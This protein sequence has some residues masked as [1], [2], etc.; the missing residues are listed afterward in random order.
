MIDQR[1]VALFGYG[2]SKAYFPAVW[3]AECDD[4]HLLDFERGNNGSGASATAGRAGHTDE[5]AE[6]DDEQHFAKQAEYGARVYAPTDAS[7]EAPAPVPAI[8]ELIPEDEVAQAK[9]VAASAIA[10]AMRRE[11]DD[12]EALLL[13]L[14]QLL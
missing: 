3:F 4:S 9:Q 11:Q 13:I 1:Q 12:E 14:A 7:P 5:Q 10:K 6:R 8:V 2:G